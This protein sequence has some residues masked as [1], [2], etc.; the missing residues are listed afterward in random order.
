MKTAVRCTSLTLGGSGANTLVAQERHGKRL[1]LTSRRA[2]TAKDGTAMDS[3]TR[4]AIG[5][6]SGA[7]QPAPLLFRIISTA[8]IFGATAAHL[9]FDLGRTIITIARAFGG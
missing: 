7:P 4:H 8:A 1:D 5:A 9:Y 3:Y 6:P 2:T